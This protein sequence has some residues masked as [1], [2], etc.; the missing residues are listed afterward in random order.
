[1]AESPEDEGPVCTVPDPGAEKDD[2]LIRDRSQLSLAVTA[3][4]DIEIL[5]EPRGER[6]VPFSPEILDRHSA[7][8]I[9]EIFAE[10]EAKQMPD[11]DGHITV[12]AEIVI[13]LQRI[14]DRAEPH[15]SPIGEPAGKM[16]IEYTVCNISYSIR[17]QDLFCKPGDKTAQSGARFLGRAAAVIDL[18]GNI[19]IFN[20][21]S[22]DQLREERD[23]Q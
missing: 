15:Q 14:A 12:P 8:R 9:T 18:I 6:N 19:V 4:R 10:R 2:H 21:R 17:D 13:D 5:L 22:C 23:I 11:A 3:E 20:D 1:M 16:V 7:V